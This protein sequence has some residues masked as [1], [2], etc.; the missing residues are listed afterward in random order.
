M[1][2][3][4]TAYLKSKQKSRPKELKKKLSA[5]ERAALKKLRREARAAGATL[6]SDG[7]GGLAPSLALGVF[8]RGKWRCSNPDCP[9]PMK[10]IDLDH[11]SG[12]AEEIA[13]DPAARNRKDLKRG[14]KL[15]HVNKLDAL[16]VLCRA[17]HNA[18]HNRER[19][20]DD[21]EKPKPMPGS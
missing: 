1:G 18:V 3:A 9:A 12:H 16:H 8:R 21:Q 11:I 5:Q 19:A 15:G 13:A 6:A 17:C 2:I 20:I 14:V 10:L 4:A 7:E